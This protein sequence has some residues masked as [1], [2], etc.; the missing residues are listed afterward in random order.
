[1]KTSVVVFKSASK[2][3]CTERKAAN[4][5]SIL[6]L[7]VMAGTLALSGCP[8]TERGREPAR[9]GAKR[10]CHDRSRCYIERLCREG[11]GSRRNEVEKRVET[12][13]GTCESSFR[14]DGLDERFDCVVSKS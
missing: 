8:T 11:G 14:T 10:S 13:G 12:P 6:F 3:R 7:A 1:M 4:G 9:K 5:V 2:A